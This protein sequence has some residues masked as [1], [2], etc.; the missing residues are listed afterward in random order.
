MKRIIVLGSKPNAVIPDGDT[1]Y[2][3]NASIAYY[4][5]QMGC[6]KHV[7][8]LVTPAAINTETTR[9]HNRWEMM[10]KTRPSRLVILG[11]VDRRI[12]ALRK[13]GYQAVITMID[14]REQ[15]KLVTRVSGCD[16]PIFT[17]Y[18]FHLPQKL[19]V[20]YAG[21]AASIILKRI[22]DQTKTCHAIFRPSTGIIT[23]LYAI[24]EKEAECEYVITGIGLKNRKDYM[25]AKRSSE[26][27]I[28]HHVFADSKILRT[29]SSRYCITT[30]EP[31]LMGILPPFTGG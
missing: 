3:A 31:E 14:E 29:I 30:T 15:R 1:I 28:P 21:S 16:D 23:L 7:V 9:H 26:D 19:K 18:F 12:D 20:R 8:N 6:F 25:L 2:C 4:A 11:D 10:S 22:V 27:S 5:D 17:A 24:D 13:S